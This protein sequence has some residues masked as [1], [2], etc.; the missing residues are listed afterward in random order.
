MARLNAAGVPCGVLVA[1]VVPGLTDHEIP[2]ILERAAEAGAVSASMLLLRLPGPVAP[3]FS[4][5][6]DRH[7]P[8]RKDKILGRIRELRG[9]RLD[10]PRFGHRMRGSGVWAE[11]IER[12]F[13]TT[14]ERLGIAPRGP[15]LSVESFRRPGGQM[16]LFSEGMRDEA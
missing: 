10:D 11:Q 6:L 14:R 8:E 2:R 9:G 15:E 5:W 7:F 13:T 3:I 16:D 1:P 4:G 12:L